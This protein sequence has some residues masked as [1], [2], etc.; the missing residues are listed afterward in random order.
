MA[1]DNYV[2]D[3]DKDFWIYSNHLIKRLLNELEVGTKKMSCV[4]DFIIHG[5]VRQALTGIAASYLSHKNY[6]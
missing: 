2:R 3:E 4:I 6:K 1:E 5:H